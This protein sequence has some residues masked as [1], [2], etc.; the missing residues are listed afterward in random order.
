MRKITIELEVSEVMDLFAGV[1]FAIPYLQ[2]ASTSPKHVLSVN[3]LTLINGK[4]QEQFNE[5]ITT[6]EYSE[7]M[8]KIQTN[9]L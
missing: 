9:D 3:R 8:K 6:E 7:L 4:I 1:Y 2:D 5:K